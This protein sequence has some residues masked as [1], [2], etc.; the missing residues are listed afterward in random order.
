MNEPVVFEWPAFRRRLGAYLS[1]RGFAY[2]A[3]DTLIGELWE[4]RDA[5]RAGASG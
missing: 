2:D 3:V 5:R 4:A 1:R